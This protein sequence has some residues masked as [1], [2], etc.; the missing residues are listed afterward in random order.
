VKTVI[1]DLDGTLVLI[2]HRRKYLEGDS[3]DWA[4]FNH[5]MIMEQDRPNE[6]IIA[7]LNALA[8]Q[9]YR[10][11]VVTGRM[12]SQR[13][14]TYKW[15]SEYCPHMLGRT[16]LMRPDG[17]YRPDHVVKEEI[18]HKLQADGHDILFVV[19][20]R[21]S[22]VEMWRRNGITCLQCAKGDF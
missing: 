14:I 8:K 13:I 6:P 17:D 22:V 2:D 7:L 10:I 20:D 11:V 12:E 15:L 5:W 1:F 19:D 18:L 21:D 9:S 3:P 4:S 16:V